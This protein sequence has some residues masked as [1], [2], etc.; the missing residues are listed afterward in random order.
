[1]VSLTEQLSPHGRGRKLASRPGLEPRPPQD[2]LADRAITTSW[3]PFPLQEQVLAT[4][5]GIYIVIAGLGG[6]KTLLGAF[7]LAKW[8]LANPRGETGEPTAALV[9]GKDFR[10]AKGTQFKWILFH[11]RSIV[12]E[13]CER[14]RELGIKSSGPLE[15][16]CTACVPLPESRLVK[17][18]RY[19][20]DPTIEL[21]N[22]C[23]IKA[24]SGTNADST[25]GPGFDFLWID[26]GEY[27]SIEAFRTGLGRLRKTPRKSA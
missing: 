15:R 17:G 2:P 23:E 8:I 10:L 13:L 25:R 6:G 7:K 19:G 5:V 27:L 1:M 22:G 3:R 26:E 20:E 21:W 11:L 16:T 18:V 9:L 24:Y 12:G 4:D 14:C